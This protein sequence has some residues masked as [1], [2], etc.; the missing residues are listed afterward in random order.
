[1]AS[2]ESGYMPVS[3]F[4]FNRVRQVNG[5][6]SKNFAYIVS[7]QEARLVFDFGVKKSLYILP[8]R[9]LLISF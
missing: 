7:N 2:L 9:S 1:M 4:F 6:T 3:L 5:L 8:K